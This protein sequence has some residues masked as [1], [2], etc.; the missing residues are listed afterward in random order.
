MFDPILHPRDGSGRFVRSGTWA[1]RLLAPLERR[2]AAAER[3]LR[4]LQSAAADRAGRA[5]RT[6]PLP[7]ERLRGND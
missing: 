2:L 1:D 3:R 4:H 5:G 6:R 7:A